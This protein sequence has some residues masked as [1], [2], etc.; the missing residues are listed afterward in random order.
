MY[1]LEDVLLKDF[2]PNPSEVGLRI[3]E[4]RFKLGYSMTEFARHIDTK[5]KSGTVS[6]WETGK[7]LP[8]NKR[9]K[10]IAELGEV[11]LLYLLKG[12]K[13]LDDLS[14]NEYETL[15]KDR[16]SYSLKFNMSLAWDLKSNFIKLENEDLSDWQVSV[17]NNSIKL[18]LA[19][20]DNDE[21]LT[22]FDS[23][24]ENSRI[25]LSEKFNKKIN[26]NEDFVHSL[27]LLEDDINT[28]KQD[29]SGLLD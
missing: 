16:E 11:S 19:F 23:L 25:V 22:L 8:N 5:A 18:I 1:K 24:I 12:E 2:K 14:E 4:I 21:V 27:V 13:S 29:V 6:N 15:S 3:K 9:L 26:K 7:N 17:L 28:L 10:K 20:S